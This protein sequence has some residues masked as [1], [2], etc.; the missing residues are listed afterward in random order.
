MIELTLKIKKE[1]KLVNILYLNKLIR[2]INL[3]K[4][5]KAIIKALLNVKKLILKITINNKRIKH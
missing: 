4:Q 3:Q 1:K 2:I 5:F